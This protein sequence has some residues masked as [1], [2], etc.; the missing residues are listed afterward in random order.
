[1]VAGPAASGF[2]TAQHHHLLLFFCGHF[3]LLR[4][5]AAG[6]ADIVEINV[7]RVERNL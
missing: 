3:C 7:Y 6:D 1:M 5:P 2:S 4:D